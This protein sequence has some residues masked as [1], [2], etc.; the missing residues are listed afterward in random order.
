[1]TRQEFL[2]NRDLSFSGW[3]RKNLPDSSEGFMV[4]DLDFILQNWKTKKIMLIEVKTRNAELR[5]WQYN[6]FSNLDKWIKKGI[7]ANWMYLGFHIVK[8]ENTCFDDGLVFFDDKVESE[9]NIVN[10]LSF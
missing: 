2:H 10:L 5:S 6:L 8:F 9:K 1:M 3:I 4:S 7:D